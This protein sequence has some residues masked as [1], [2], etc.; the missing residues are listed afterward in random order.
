MKLKVGDVVEFKKYTDMT[1]DETE[2]VPENEFPKYGKVK[3]VIVDDEKAL[4][5]SIEESQYGFSA[6]SVARVLSDVDVDSLNVGD[7]VLVKAII[8][9]FFSGL[10][11]IE[12][13]VYKTDVVKILKRQVPEYFIVQENHYGMYIGRG[14][15]LVSDKSK[16][17]IY[18]LR[19]TA[20]DDAV[21]MHLSKWN[22][23]P[24]DD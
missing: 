13:S 9:N 16:A 23:I 17:K 3:E 10:L 4:Y 18:T 2:W 20:D 11:Q 19:D 12:P 15:E 7:E 14:L 6:K 5:F 1:N 24:Y 22:V 8:K 21:D